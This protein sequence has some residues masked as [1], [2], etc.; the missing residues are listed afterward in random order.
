M[1]FN[2]KEKFDVQDSDEKMF[3]HEHEFM[4]RKY[5]LFLVTKLFM[6]KKG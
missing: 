6:V 4:F 2:G 1:S 3:D 5:A